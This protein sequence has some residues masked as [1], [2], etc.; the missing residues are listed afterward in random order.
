[1]TIKRWWSANRCQ[2]QT[3]ENRKIKGEG[4]LNEQKQ[5]DF[6]VEVQRIY[7]HCKFITTPPLNTNSELS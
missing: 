3:P 6:Q 5:V 4:K 7:T 2:K 1:M